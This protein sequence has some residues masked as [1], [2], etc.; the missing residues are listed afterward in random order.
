MNFNSLRN[1]KKVFFAV[2]FAVYT[3]FVV[4]NFITPLMGED[5]ILVAFSKNYE[6]TSATDL[7]SRMLHRIY[8][9]MT[10]WNV[11]IGEQFS[12]VFSCF[13][14][15]VFDIFNSIIS[16]VYIWLI[17]QYA[18]KRKIS[19]TKTEAMKILAV[20]A[21]IIIAQPA[22]GEIFFWRTG[23]TNYLWAICLLLFFALPLRYYVGYELIDVIGDSKIK[24]VLITIL[25][26]FAGFTNENTIAVFIV[27]YIGICIYNYR[28]KKKTPVW[29]YS[30]G[31]SLTIGFL[32]M[33]EAP[34]TKIRVET[35]NQ[36][37]G[38]EQVTI[39]DYLTRAQNIIQRFFCDNRMLIIITVTFIVLD[40]ACVLWESREEHNNR[41]ILI[42]QRSENLGL[43]FLSAISCGA[44]V[45]SP[46]IETR[47]FLLPDF[48]MVVCIIYYLDLMLKRIKKHA[49]IIKVIVGLC[50]LA[51]CVC[52]G[53]TIFDTYNDYSKYVQLRNSAVELEQGS[54]IWGEYQ[55]PYS[56][57]IL[58]TREDY[59]MSNETG[60][61]N[62]YSKE[63]RCWNNYIW[64]M[65]YS[66]YAE[67]EVIGNMDSVTYNT[68]NDSLSVYGWATLTDEDAD[69]CE[70][71]VYLEL[72][73]K[74]Y[75]FKTQKIQRED[76]VA[77][78]EKKDY[79][80]SGYQVEIESIKEMLGTDTD[81]ITIGL[82]T[83]NQK[84][85]EVESQTIHQKIKL[86]KNTK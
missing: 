1:E 44:L 49:R 22:I 51:I 21:V 10:G 31:A 73:G 11:R 56:S 2:V 72:N 42:L 67:H 38:I 50:I 30:S 65:D 61:N 15:I 68:E 79:L 60:L 77:A 36:I 46:Y 80:N 43:L 53:T 74:R 70:N 34:S 86:N 78:C 69:E 66:G 63:I 23:S 33:Y 57:R 41:R 14:K 18:F 59:L 85:S 64:N 4:I 17:F 8:N 9:Q 71:Y 13:D 58:T 52:E 32:C 19:I 54:F 81:E 48:L 40:T 5:L 3:F 12:I 75:Y 28:R 27:L 84:N 25:G 39:Q 26:F 16:L 29:I 45:M 20:F 37:F 55:K 83:I 76:V 82:C 24:I 6:V 47:A 62:F 35:Y 7:L